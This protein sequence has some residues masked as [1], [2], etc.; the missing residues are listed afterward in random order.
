MDVFVRRLPESVTRLDLIH[1]ISSALKPHWT[2]FGMTL[3]PENIDCQILRVT[4]IDKQTVEYHG[5]AHFAKP[6]EAVAVIARLNGEFF[7]EKQMEVRKYFHRS[8]L[9]DRRQQTTS[10]LTAPEEEQRREERR[11]AGLLIEEFHAGATRAHGYSPQLH[12]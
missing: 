8:P 4:D 5:I 3:K 9:R 12:A 2:L 10:P 7:K 1:F 11:R 6:N